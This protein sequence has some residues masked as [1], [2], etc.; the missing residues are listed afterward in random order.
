RQ[1]EQKK[2]CSKFLTFTDIQIFSTSPV[3]PFSLALCKLYKGDFCE[4]YFFTNKG[5]TNIQVIFYST[6]DK[7]LMLVQDN[8]GLHS[9]IPLASTK[10]K[11]SII[12][13][14]DLT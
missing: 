3:I 8:H 14:K 2:N 5:L 10:V 9:F 13:D 11:Q 7:A 12:D 1:D 6:D 4:L